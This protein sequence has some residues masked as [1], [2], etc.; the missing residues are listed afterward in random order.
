[1]ADP[2]Q[3]LHELLCHASAC[4]SPPDACSSHGSRCVAARAALTHLRLCGPAC[5][6]SAAKA[7][8]HFRQL[9]SL[10]KEHAA[11][12][13]L[14]IDSA[15]CRVAR[16]D[17]LRRLAASVRTQL[18]SLTFE[19]EGITDPERCRHPPIPFARLATY[20][21]GPHGE[22]VGAATR[23][24]LPGTPRD[25]GVPLLAWLE[26]SVAMPGLTSAA[27]QTQ[28]TGGALPPGTCSVSELEGL[29]LCELAR[30]G[31]FEALAAALA[32]A[33]MAAARHPQQHTDACCVARRVA[34]ALAD[35]LMASGN[36]ALQRIRR[37][38][39]SPLPRVLA[40]CAQRWQG[41]L[42]LQHTAPG[43]MTLLLAPSPDE[44]AT[45]APLQRREAIKIWAGPVAALLVAATGEADAKQQHPAQRKVR[46]AAAWREKR[47][48]LTTGLLR[49]TAALAAEQCSRRAALAHGLGTAAVGVLT[50]CACDRSR[51]SNTAIA[52]AAARQVAKALGVEPQLMRSPEGVRFISAT[53]AL[54]LTAQ[55]PALQ[56][57]AC[58]YVL[59]PMA[60]A[61]RAVSTSHVCRQPCCASAAAAPATLAALIAVPGALEALGQ[62]AR[63]V[64]GARKAAAATL[65]A[66]LG[67]DG[68]S[69]A[70]AHAA[71][72]GLQPAVAE[73]LGAAR[74][75]AALPAA[76]QLQ[77]RQQRRLAK[78]PGAS[79]APPPEPCGSRFD[80][81]GC[82]S[83][84]GAAS[85]EDED[86]GSAPFA[87][88]ALAALDAAATGQ[89]PP[90]P[91][92]HRDASATQDADAAAA[93]LSLAEED[94]ASDIAASSSA[95]AKDKDKKKSKGLAS[96]DDA[97]AQVASMSLDTRRSNAAACRDACCAPGAGGPFRL[98]PRAR[99]TP[100][101]AAAATAPVV[102]SASKAGI[103]A[104]TAP[105]AN[106]LS[107]LFP[108]LFPPAAA[109]L[110]AQAPSDNDADAD[111]DFVPASLG[112]V[113]AAAQPP[114]ADDAPPDARCVGCLAAPR[115]TPLPGCA[116][117]SPQR[118]VLTMCD[119]FSHGGL[120]FTAH[121]WV[122]GV[123][124]QAGA[125]SRSR[126]GGG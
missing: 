53:A 110:P 72:P 22:P 78:R 77:Q 13:T 122:D 65:A 49:A 68:A 48:Q 70:A 30:R 61:E 39:A 63:R 109:A 116:A 79:K 76:Q 81:G 101:P 73:A 115:D 84:C 7:P 32:S 42:P 28:R 24:R 6:A 29:R 51:C 37:L 14:P 20:A 54:L 94:E 36:N 113:V 91:T 47:W 5:A 15:S 102:A 55:Q 8:D 95:S 18:A 31:D 121:L 62:A 75:N 44:D 67:A 86:G 96:A 52:G 35:S 107:A 10:A 23:V 106:A 45:I 71:A 83:D 120:A 58:V 100:P 9:A 21:Q 56:R 19:L 80:P 4:A 82:D 112:F 11:R 111:D 1:M 99:H 33:L 26:G 27:P 88:A 90:P 46:D 43:V 105:A 92:P 124:E 17:A 50:D 59:L 85:D 114:P 126:G 16:C 25:A 118:V 38:Q 64:A 2:Q 89:P 60:R 117:N 66:L 3:Q 125:A 103:D 57:W 41:C 119:G 97:A 123:A 104:T 98:G 12:C 87:A 108:S 93:A 69:A 34:A 40:F 74:A